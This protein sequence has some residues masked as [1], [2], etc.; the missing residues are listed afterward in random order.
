MQI[1][2]VSAAVPSA[3]ALMTQ[4]GKLSHL[5]PKE[6]VE[7]VSK[8]FEAV[9]LRQFLQESVGSIMGGKEAGVAGGVYGF[10]LTDALANQIS[11]SG[12]L[13][14]SKVLQQQLSPRTALAAAP[15]TQN[16]E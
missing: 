13:G 6:Q 10:M 15:A 12:G 9:L 11:Q 8:Q 7:A 3:A 5:S 1:S 16:P 14:M 2:P 4:P